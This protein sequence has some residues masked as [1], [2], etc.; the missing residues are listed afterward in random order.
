MKSSTSTI[1]ELP[2]HPNAIIRFARP[3]HLTPTYTSEE[4]NLRT[5]TTRTYT[6]QKKSRIEQRR[7]RTRTFATDPFRARF[8]VRLPQGMRQ[9][10]RNMEWKDFINAYAPADIRV[11]HIETVRQRAGLHEYTI[12]IKDP[13]G[14][15]AGA[16]DLTATIQ[17][18]GVA[19]AITEILCDRGLPVEIREFH[20]FPIFQ[21]TATFLYV[22]DGNKR[23]WALGFGA[24]PELSICNAI[25]AGATNLHLR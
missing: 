8:G 18:M 22:S 24:T 20:Q 19:R 11:D 3:E 2:Q 5:S 1:F 23:V 7:R 12:T 6:T 9:E 21:A 10:A 15:G 25:C 16:T 14:S 17:S 13:T 4:R